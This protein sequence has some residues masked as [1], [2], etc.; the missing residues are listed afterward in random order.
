LLAAAGDAAD[1][2]AT[3]PASAATTPTSTATTSTS[4]AASYGAAPRAAAPGKIMSQTSP[5]EMT[6]TLGVL[7]ILWRSDC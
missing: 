1:A 6:F 3:T 7:L 5:L 2:A 4:A